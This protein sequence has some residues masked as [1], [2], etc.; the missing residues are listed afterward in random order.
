M[1][2]CCAADLY[3]AVKWVLWVLFQQSDEW[4][5]F[6]GANIRKK[7][8][9]KL[10]HKIVADWISSDSRWSRKYF[11]FTCCAFCHTIHL[12]FIY[13]FSAAYPG[14]GHGGSS[15]SRN[16]QTPLS[17]ATSSRSSE[18][19]PRRSQASWRIQSFQHGSGPA[20]VPPPSRTCPEYL[21]RETTGHVNVPY[22]P[23]VWTTS[24][25]SFQSGEAPALLWAPPGCP[26]SYPQ[27]WAPPPCGGN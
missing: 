13:S 10:W 6:A 12:S 9:N 23:G 14:P 2:M 11:F 22:W 5:I 1:R 18:E 27:K 19:S 7:I 16:P 20:L 24:T 15:L 8:E 4:Q 17:T 3:V 21:P 26:S 25:G